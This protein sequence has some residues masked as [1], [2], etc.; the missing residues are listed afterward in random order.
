MDSPSTELSDF[1][2]EMDMYLLTSYQPIKNMLPISGITTGHNTRS[3]GDALIQ[4]KKECITCWYCNRTTYNM[5]R[6]Q[7]ASCKAG[8]VCV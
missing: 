6:M 5:A 4:G 2:A 1:F 7:C 3:S 8:F